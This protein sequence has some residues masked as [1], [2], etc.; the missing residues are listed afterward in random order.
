MS[1]GTTIVAAMG[2]KHLDLLNHCIS[3]PAMTLL[4]QGALTAFLGAFVLLIRRKVEPES[5]RQ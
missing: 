3:A 2:D 1:T 5:Y 4:V